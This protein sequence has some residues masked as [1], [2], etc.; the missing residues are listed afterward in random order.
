MPRAN[1]L[2]NIIHSR[3]DRYNS[4]EENLEQKMIQQ[5]G[6]QRIPSVERTEGRLLVGTVSRR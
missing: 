6:E 4:T 3:K 5:P 2:T 1:I